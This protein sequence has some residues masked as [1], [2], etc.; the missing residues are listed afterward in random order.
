MRVTSMTDDFA[1]GIIFK[2]I[3]ENLTK[4]E[5]K[6]PL[7]EDVQAKERQK[8]NLASILQKIEDLTK[9]IITQT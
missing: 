6:L 9:Y 4:N 7:G 1:D 8:K 3:L 2:K 5:I